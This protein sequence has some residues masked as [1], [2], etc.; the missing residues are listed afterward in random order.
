MNFQ[1]FLKD[2]QPAA[3]LFEADDKINRRPS[4]LICACAA[5]EKFDDVFSVRIKLKQ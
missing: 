2:R 3:A 4:I 1:K 5:D